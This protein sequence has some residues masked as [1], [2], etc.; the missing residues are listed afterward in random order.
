MQLRRG[1]ITRWRLLREVPPGQVTGAE[2]TPSMISG[3]VRVHVR[4]DAP[5]RVRSQTKAVSRQ[6]VDGVNA[7]VHGRR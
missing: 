7:L 4:D 2:Y 6:F 3:Q 5:I 1:T